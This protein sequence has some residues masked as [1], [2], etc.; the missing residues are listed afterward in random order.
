MTFDKTALTSAGF[1]SWDELYNTDHL[2][3]L[4]RM[5]EREIAVAPSDAF[6]AILVLRSV[7]DLAAASRRLESLN[8]RLERLTWAIAILA[9]LTLV[10]AGIALFK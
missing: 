9:S 8:Q 5:D 7:A 2:E 1:K 3:V 4:R 6:L 10:A